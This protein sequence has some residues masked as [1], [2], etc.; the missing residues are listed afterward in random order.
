MACGNDDG[1]W[2][3]LEDDIIGLEAEQRV[4]ITFE[5]WLAALHYYCCVR[6]RLT[7]ACRTCVLTC[8]G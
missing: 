6:R 4:Q 8:A 7:P 1:I 2:I 5:G 3:S